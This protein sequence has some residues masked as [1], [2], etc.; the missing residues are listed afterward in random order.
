M[1]TT[2]ANCEHQYHIITDFVY[3][4]FPTFNRGFVLYENTLYTIDTSQ[5]TDSR[6]FCENY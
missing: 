2:S 3:I 6:E 5:F 1:S 4:G